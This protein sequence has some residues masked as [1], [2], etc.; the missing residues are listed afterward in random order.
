MSKSTIILV[1]VLFP[2]SSSMGV[3]VVKNDPTKIELPEYNVTAQNAYAELVRRSR[4]PLQEPETFQAKTFDDG[5]VIIYA[6][7]IKI[8]EITTNPINTIQEPPDR[9]WYVT[10]P[11]EIWNIRHR[12]IVQTWLMQRE[13]PRP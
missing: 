5:T 4:I 1:P 11:S 6:P 3:L 13:F 12:M 2:K 7:S 8:T 9:I 10:R